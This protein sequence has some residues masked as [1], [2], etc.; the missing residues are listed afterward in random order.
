MFKHNQPLFGLA[1]VV[2]LLG[3]IALV[4]PRLTNGQ[5]SDA[6]GGP[7]KLPQNV[8][9][10]NTP[11][12]IT[13]TVA[14]ENSSG[15]PLLV[16]DIDT[17]T[18]QP[19]QRRIQIPL[20]ESQSTIHVP[21]GKRLVLEYG[22]IDVTVEQNCRVAFISIQTEV[23]GAKADHLISI[24]SHTTIGTRNVDLAGQQIKLYSDP[25]TD[26]T[27]NFAFSGDNCQPAGLMAVSG[28]FENVPQP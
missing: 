24:S 4:T 27:V 11:L 12:P 19:F 7:N 28:Y 6:P 10:V 22:S 9:V 1:G 3:T 20:I 23:G 17:S 14:V 16:R 15:S 25:G 2:L 26:T 8:N 21:E 18:R 13:G 5:K